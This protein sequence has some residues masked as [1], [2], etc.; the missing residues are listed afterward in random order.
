MDSGTGVADL[1]SGGHGRAVLETGGCHRAA[2]R[3]RDD[4]VGLEVEILAR[5]ESLDGGIDQ[6]RVDLTQPLPWETEPIDDAGTEVL[7]KDVDARHQSGEDALA[8]VALH[9]Q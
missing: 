6:P 3:L 5:T 9:V 4:L 2:H 8:L 1:C 7:D